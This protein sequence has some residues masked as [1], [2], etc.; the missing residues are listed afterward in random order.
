[1]LKFSVLKYCLL[2]AQ[3][4][5]VGAAVVFMDAL[6]RAE[7]E[8]AWVQLTA[9]SKWLHY[10]QY[11]EQHWEKGIGCGLLLS[12]ITAVTALEQH[13]VCC[14]LLKCSSIHNW[15]LVDVP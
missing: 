7:L 14:T 13:R 5:G 6:E 8:G 12:S 15:C 9:S 10:E 3:R 11:E 2:K 4:E 1:M